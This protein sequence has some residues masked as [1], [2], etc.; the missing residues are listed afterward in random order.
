MAVVDR[1]FPDR[2]IA[3]RVGGSPLIIGIGDGEYILA[4]DIRLVGCSPQCSSFKL[5]YRTLYGSRY[6]FCI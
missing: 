5:Y 3:A 2:L 1:E 6:A 4:S